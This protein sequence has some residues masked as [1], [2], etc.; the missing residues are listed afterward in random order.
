MLRMTSAFRLGIQLHCRLEHPVRAGLVIV[1]CHH[2]FKAPRLSTTSAISRES[3]A[4]ATRP[5]CG[6]RCLPRDANDHR[7]S[8]DVGERFARQPWPTPF[9]PE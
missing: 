5:T 3:V 1:A 8:A 4:T 9:G 7:H 6:E 2:S